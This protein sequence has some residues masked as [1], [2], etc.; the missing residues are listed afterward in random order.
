MTEMVPWERLHDESAKAFQAFALY[1]DLGPRERSLRRVAAELGRDRSLIERWS[2]RHRWQ[3]RVAAYDAE[4]DRRKLARRWKDIEEMSERH[5]KLALAVQAKLA[6]RLENLDPMELAPRDLVQLLDTAVRVERLAFGVGT[7]HLRHE[8][9]GP[10]GLPVQLE[11]ISERD[12][13]RIGQVMDV[14]A[15]LGV[16]P[17]APDDAAALVGGDNAQVEPVPGGDREDADA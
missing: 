11:V 3:D 16:L 8:V 10:G 17:P 15:Q 5:A 14:L 13:D 12:V 2:V 1:R 4:E 7:E 9:A 6:R